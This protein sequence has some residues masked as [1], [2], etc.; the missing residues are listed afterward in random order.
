MTHTNVRRAK[1]GLTDIDIEHLALH[2]QVGKE[3]VECLLDRRPCIGDCW[4]ER[5]LLHARRP[6]TNGLPG[7][8]DRLVAVHPVKNGLAKLTT[9]FLTG[10]ELKNLSKNAFTRHESRF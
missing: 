10:F 8:L 3:R 9:A 4:A 5:D 6:N 1:N 2:L 7:F